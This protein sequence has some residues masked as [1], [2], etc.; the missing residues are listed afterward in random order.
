MRIEI[1]YAGQILE[2]NISDKNFEQII[3]P[4][5]IGSLNES[6]LLTEAINNPVNSKKFDD[7]IKDAKQLLFIVNDGTRPTPTAKVLRNIYKKIKDKKLRFIIATGAHRSAREE[8]LKNIFQEFYEEFHSLTIS[9]DA[10]AKNEMTFLGTTTNGNKI[11]LN[12]LVFDSD[13][14]VVIGSVEPHYFA[15]F[16]GGRKAFLPGVADINSIKANHKLALKTLNQIM[17]LENNPVH[18]EMEETVFMLK[19]KEIFSI[20]T[21]LDREDKICFAS[22]GD[23][24]TSFEMASKKAKDIFSVHINEKVDIA[25]AIVESPM[26]INFYQTQKAIHNVSGVLNPGGILI[27]VSCCKEGLGRKGFLELLSSETNYKEIFKKINNGYE[28]GYHIAAKIAKIAAN[29]EIWVVTDLKK[30]LIESKFIKAFNSIQEAVNVALELKKDKKILFVRSASMLIP[31][32]K[33]E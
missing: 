4:K 26:D 25:V 10:Y 9:H 27:I 6:K 19:E 18:D 29:N 12:K 2:C 28:L 7:F 22:A 33:T 11:L 32:V 16:T 21:V 13:K 3:F 15:G 8:E 20:M 14:I 30:E 5:N 1:P 31:L 17:K 24:T 23:I